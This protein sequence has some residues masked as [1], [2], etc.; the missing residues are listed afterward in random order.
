MSIRIATVAGA[1]GLT[2]SK[3]VEQLLE[4]DYYSGIRILI[5]HPVALEHPKLEKKLVDF[6]DMDSLLVAITGSEALFCT[7]GTTNKKVR[8]D[9]S[10]YRNIDLVIAENLA[11]SCRIC[12]CDKFI[13][14][15]AAGAS[16]S[17]SNFY[18]RLKG[19]TEEAVKASGV[20]FIHILQP[21]LLLGKRS[22]FRP[23]ERL[24]QAVMRFLSFLL[25]ARIKP[26]PAGFVAR[27]M[28]MASKSARQGVRIYTNK[29]I[30][31]AAL[32]G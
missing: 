26:V 24:A 1:T 9:R 8:G 14:V 17:S 30:M 18:L 31:E 19:E 25:P 27:A 4:D 12:G 10:A 5:R 22:E 32:Q 23:G 13:L 3:L 2:G 21:S 28:I 6:S 29:A 11:R 16:R 15:S 7:I 20:P